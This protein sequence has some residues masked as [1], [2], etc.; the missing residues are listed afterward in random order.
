[1]KINQFFSLLCL[2]VIALVFVSCIDTAGGGVT[3]RLEDFQEVGASVAAREWKDDYDCSNFSVQ[4]YQNCYEAGLPCRIR[5]GISGGSQFGVGS[6]A[7]NSV[8]INGEWVNWEPQLNDIY[9]GHD[10]TW[11]PIEGWGNIVEEDISRIEYEMIGRYVPESMINLYEIDANIYDSTAFYPFFVPRAYCFSNDPNA[12]Y[13]VSQFEA[14]FPEN[15][16]GAMYLFDS[17]YLIFIFKFSGKYYG[18][19]ENDPFEGRSI[20]DGSNLKD[21]IRSGVDFVKI[22]VDRTF[23]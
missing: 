7:W 10:Q 15:K 6:H 12:Q 18:M 3:Y 19:E 4:F 5:F 2:C 20:A 8:E 11:N 23:E 14:E 22:D 21:I 13:L 17:M 1:M 9:N 16:D